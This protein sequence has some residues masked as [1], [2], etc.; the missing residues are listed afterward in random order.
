MILWLSS[1]LIRHLSILQ[2]SYKSMKSKVHLE[3]LNAVL[4][5]S[6]ECSGGGEGSE[7]QAP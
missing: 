1:V 3:D 6:V 5:K 7:A 4:D 2:K